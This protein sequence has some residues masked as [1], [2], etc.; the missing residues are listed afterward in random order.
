ML[1]FLLKQ[2][3]AGPAHIKREYITS[4]ED[5]ARLSVDWLREGEDD[6]SPDAPLLLILPTISGDGPSHAYVMRAAAER[7]WRSCVLN[8]RGLAERLETPRFNVMGDQ[9]DVHAQVKYVRSKYARATFVGLMGISGGSGSLV[10]YLGSTRTKLIDAGCCLCPAYDIN[11]AFSTFKQR[12]PLVDAYL[13][14]DVV[15]KYVRSNE[16]VLRMYDDDA[17]DACLRAESVDAFMRAHVP[18]TTSPTQRA[19]FE[20][21]NP[22]QHVLGISCPLLILNAEDDMVCL[23]ENIREDLANDHGG[24]LLLRTEEGSHVAFSEGAFG[25][26]NFMVRTSLDFLDAARRCGVRAEHVE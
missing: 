5:G 4:P 15:D 22:M 7:G 20:R 10:T 9:D 24:V 8:R 21:S 2:R 6:L 1:V 17:T 12:Y 26:G 23:R 3:L 13:L 14:R 11:S 18:F 19:Y 25:L 16:R